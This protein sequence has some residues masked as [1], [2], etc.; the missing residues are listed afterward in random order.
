M[1]QDESVV[2]IPEEEIYEKIEQAVLQVPEVSHFTSDGF[3]EMLNGISQAFGFGRHKGILLRKSRKNGIKVDLSLAL[4]HGCRVVET[5]RYIQMLI[6][7]LLLSVTDGPV[8][9]I[10]VTITDIV[11]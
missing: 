11:D 6:R 3:Q 4:H 5:A 1:S 10:D 8:Y 7:N 2:I 9:G